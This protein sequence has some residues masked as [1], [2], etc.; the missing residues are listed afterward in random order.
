MAEANLSHI[1]IVFS[2]RFLN[3]H[4]TKSPP[5]MGKQKARTS[6][7][8]IV[9]K[10][11]QSFCVVTSFLH[12]YIGILGGAPPAHL[13]RMC[14]NPCARLDTNPLHL[15]GGFPEMQCNRAREGDK[16][17]SRGALMNDGEG[18]FVTHSGTQIAC[19]A[20]IQPGRCAHKSCS[21]QCAASLPASTGAW[22]ARNRAASTAASRNFL[23]ECC[24][25]PWRRG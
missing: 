12:F 17:G 25:N 21:S 5:G 24:R 7:T 16:S 22:S 23:S 15:S 1:S 4:T 20:A 13:L 3:R 6:A 19:S 9:D 2:S 8:T 14:C 10:V 18:L 11:S